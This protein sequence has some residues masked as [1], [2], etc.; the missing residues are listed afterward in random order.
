MFSRMYTRFAM[1][2]SMGFE[3][4][5]LV[6]LAYLYWKNNNHFCMIILTPGAN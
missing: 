5:N 1:K 3:A 4:R 2:T 6:S